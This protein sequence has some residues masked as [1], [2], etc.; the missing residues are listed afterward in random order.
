MPSILRSRQAPWLGPG[1]K[2]LA[3][4]P[5]STMCVPAPAL[6]AVCIF[7]G[8]PP[9]IVGSAIPIRDRRLDAQARAFVSSILS[10]F[11]SRPSFIAGE[12]S[13][14]RVIDQ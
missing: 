5:R 2:D 14:R 4:Y 3:L 6:T 1:R 11:L 12:L 7:I 13:Q 10:T 8:S 9:F